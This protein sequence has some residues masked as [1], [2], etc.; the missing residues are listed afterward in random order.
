MS[1]PDGH[2][3]SVFIGIHHQTHSIMCW[4][5][6]VQACNMAKQKYATIYHKMSPMVDKPDLCS[7]S[8]L[9]TAYNHVSIAKYLMWKASSVFMLAGG[10]KNVSCFCTIEQ[11]RYYQCQW[12]RCTLV[13]IL[14][15]QHFHSP[16]IGYDWH[17]RRE[18]R[19][20]SNGPR[21]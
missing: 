5:S 12:Y 14:R 2:W 19:K 20:F 11:N 15:D 21:H 8:A 13:L 7:T 17:A 10:G 1:S 3:L 4:Y 16:G 18:L 9:E 6:R